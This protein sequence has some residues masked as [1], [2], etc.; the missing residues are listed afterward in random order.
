MIFELNI[1]ITDD[2]YEAESHSIA[3]YENESPLCISTIIRGQEAFL[4]I[5]E[6]EQN[7][8]NDPDFLSQKAEGKL[9][10][11]DPFKVATFEPQN[12]AFVIR[13]YV[14]KVHNKLRGH[15]HPWIKKFTQ[16]FWDRCIL[17]L[18]INNYMDYPQLARSSFEDELEQIIML[19]KWKIIKDRTAQSN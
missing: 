15:L 14:S 11:F 13:F 16:Y 19:K 5:G 10:L 17:T 8:A 3:F 18:D 6:P 2:S 12:A 1:K 7:F 4:A 9:R